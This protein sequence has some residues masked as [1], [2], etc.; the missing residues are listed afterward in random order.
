MAVLQEIRKRPWILIGFIAVALLAFLVNPS[1]FD[2]FF[3]KN[4]NILGKVNGEEISRSELQDQIELIRQQSQGQPMSEAQLEQQAWNNM[5]QFKL[6]EQEF[7]SMGLEITEDYFWNQVQFDPMFQNNPQMMDEKGNFKTQMLK[8]EVAKF[9]ATAEGATNWAKMKRAM[10]YRMMGRQLFANFSGAITANNKEA[11]ELLK[12]RDELV[13]FQYVKADYASFGKKNP[14]KVNTEDIANYIQKHPLQFKVDASV[15]MS[16]VFFPAKAS[17]QDDA[18]ILNEITKLNT[19][20][21]EM[22]NGIESFQNTKNDSM[23]VSINSEVPFSG[24][25]MPIAQLPENIK[26]FAKTAT[27]GQTFGPYKYQN[28]LYVV[29]KLLGKKAEDSIQSKHI[30]I[31]YKGNEVAQGDASVKRSKEEAKKLAETTLSEI[32]ANPSKFD[33]YLSLSSDKGSAAQGGIVE[34]TTPSAPKFVSEFQKFIETNPKGALG[35]VESK[36]G[37]HII[38]IT[39]KK[40][41]GLGYKIANLAKYIKPSTSTTDKIYSTANKFIQDV[42]GKSIND[43]NNIAKKSNYT[44][45]AQKTLQ[46]FGGGIPNLNTDK[47]TEI[48]TWAFDKK[49]EKG[50]TNIFTTGNG[51]Y[52][53][54]YY[55]GKQDAGLANPESVRAQVES[56]VK[57]QLLA[58]KMKEK[59]GSISTLDAAAKAMGTSVKSAEAGL[60]NPMIENTMEPKVV[61]AAYGVAKAKISKAIE[62]QSGVF[63]V[64]K[65]GLKTNKQPGDAKQ[66]V[67]MMSQQ[68]QQTI[69]QAFIKSLQD[70]AVIK[71]FRTEIYQQASES[72]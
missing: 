61:G 65:T 13:Q 7:K 59:L 63:L 22:G 54:T 48:L 9:T 33:S 34:W 47:D 66:F 20:G 5:V 10:E 57:N 37:F 38:Q 21:V 50:E 19:M 52:I 68:Y 43:F 17:A 41:G 24:A 14:I 67:Q 42:Q 28:Q 16:L 55:N 44:V 53:I 35:L 15:D 11:S 3:A 45:N 27:A 29:S 2:K 32:K 71:D 69:P 30:L 25:Y 60:F 40:A 39:D 36:F 12:Q 1:S 18:K 8:D 62:G 49:R 72:K 26:E 23:F 70:N 58:A 4:P 56:I 51:D 46:R 64:S 31:T 6:V